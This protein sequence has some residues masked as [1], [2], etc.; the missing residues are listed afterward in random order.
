MMKKRFIERKDGFMID[1][2]FA[3]CMA[4]PFW[5]SWFFGWRLTNEQGCTFI[6]S[7]KAWKELEEYINTYIK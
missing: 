6:L 5:W 4:K 2:A 1:M 7:K 3:Y